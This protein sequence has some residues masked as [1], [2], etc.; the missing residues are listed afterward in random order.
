MQQGEIPD[1]TGGFLPNMTKHNVPVRDFHAQFNPCSASVT[2][3]SP[4][5]HL[6]FKN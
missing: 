5:P 1:E 6:L 2:N 4:W 3:G